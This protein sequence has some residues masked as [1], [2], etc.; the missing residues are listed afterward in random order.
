MRSGPDCPGPLSSGLDS[1]GIINIPGLNGSIFLKFVTSNFAEVESVKIEI[2][3]M[4]TSYLTTYFIKYEV[5]YIMSCRIMPT[6]VVN[7]LELA[8]L[9]ILSHFS[10]I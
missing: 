3:D 10:D 8:T 2:K 5:F 7:C 6:Q 4:S 1:G 9:R